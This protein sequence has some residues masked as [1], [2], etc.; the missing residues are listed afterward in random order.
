MPKQYISEIITQDEIKKWQAGNRILICSQ[1]GTGKSEFIK[2]NLYNY[3][4]QNNL[5]IL[6]LS[7]RSILKSQNL[8]DLEDKLDFI[9]AHNYQEFEAKTLGGFNPKDIFADYSIIVYDEAHY[10]FS[11]SQFNRNTDLLIDPI[12]NTPGDKIFIF[13]TATPEALKLYQPKFDYVYNAPIDYSYIDKLYFYSKQET[14]R[15]IIQKIPQTEKGLFFASDAFDAYELSVETPNAE[16]ICSVGHKDLARKSNKQVLKE[17]ANNNKFDCHLLC[18]TKVL[19]NGIN[20]IDPDLKH[21]IIDM[22]DPTEFLQ[23]LGRKRI[24]PNEKI[25]VYVKDFSGG[26]IYPQITSIQSKLKTVDELNEIGIEEFQ[27]RYKKKDFDNVI[28]N[29]F[30]VNQAKLYYYYQF[31]NYLQWMLND[32]DKAGYQKE[33]CYKMQYP[34]ASIKNAEIE[35]ERMTLDQELEKL[36]NIPLFDKDIDKFK[37]MFFNRK[38]SP[39]KTDYHKRG[40]LCINAILQEDNSDYLVISG[41]S[42]KS[43]TREKRYWMITSKF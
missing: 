5:K 12:K 15:E 21:I 7:N 11:D 4:K 1:T 6:L 39:K 37:N 14:L 34:F 20:L 9:D 43:D 40:I 28:Q 30:S 13:L 2:T 23:C 32:K 17:I 24:A 18:C 38:F 36:L 25:T 41:K 42:R 8:N 35:F 10:I 22:L 3:C 27:I 19:D 29:D 16:F 26:T 33:I 31:R